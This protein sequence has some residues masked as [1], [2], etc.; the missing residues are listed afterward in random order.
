MTNPT[1]FDDIIDSRDIIERLEELEENRKPWAAGWNMPGYL[2]DSEPGAFAAWADARDYIEA[3]LTR[4]ADDAEDEEEAAE[5]TLAAARMP[6]LDEDQEFG[7]TIGR[8]HWWIT[9]SES[10]FKLPEEADEYRA[11]KELAE[12]AAQYSE[13]WEYG[14]TLVRDSYFETYAQ[15]LA[16]DIG[17]VNNDATWPNNCIDWERAARELQ[18]DYTAVDFDGVQY[19]IRS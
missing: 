1:R 14:A 13:D 2:P 10:E 16:E 6:D 7:A 5:Y 17:A 9:R 19:W 8:G 3:E 15:E 12:E 11:L 4:A 18:L